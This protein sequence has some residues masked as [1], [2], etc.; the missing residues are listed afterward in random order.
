M[1]GNQP[2][3]VRG[4]PVAMSSWTRGLLACG[5]SVLGIAAIG[6][7]VGYCSLDNPQLVQGAA[8][9]AT[10]V[11]GGFGTDS[12]KR[13]YRSFRAR[14]GRPT[15]ENP[16]IL[17][18]LRS[19]QLSA[20]RTISTRFDKARRSDNDPSRRSHAELFM[21][22]LGQHL[23]REE[24][25]AETLV[26][27]DLPEPTDADIETL[28]FAVSRHA[29]ADP[30]I[31]RARTV[32]RASEDLSAA[33]SIR[34][35]GG[36]TLDRFRVAAEAAM[37]AELAAAVHPD[38]PPAFGHLLLGGRDS[39]DGWFALFIRAAAERLR[40][41]PGFRR[42]WQAEQDAVLLDLARQAVHGVAEVRHIGQAATKALARYGE[43]LGAVADTTKQA[44]DLL[45][46]MSE[47]L[48]DVRGWLHWN[49]NFKPEGWTRFH[50]FNRAIPFQGRE[51][52]LE[53][54]AAFLHTAGPFSWWIATGPGGAGKTRLALELCLRAHLGGWQVGFLRKPFDMPAATWR[55]ARPTLI[56][57]D[58]AGEQADRVRELAVLLSGLGEGLPVVRLLLLERVADDF[59]LRRFYGASGKDTGAIAATRYSDKWL[60]FGELSEDE[61]WSLVADCPWRV[62]P[63]ALVI[64]RAE[65]FAH[66][67]ET[68]RDHRVLVAMLIAEAMAEYPDRPTLTELTEVLQ[69]LLTN[70][71]ERHWPPELGTRGATA[72]R[73]GVAHPA[74]ALIAAATMTG[75]L[76]GDFLRDVERELG[77]AVSG[78]MLDCCAHAI[79]SPAHPDVRRLDG[80][81]PD[82]IGEFFALQAL[83]CDPR[84]PPRF[85]WLPELAWRAD[86]VRMA[87]FVRRARQNFPCHAAL[88]QI[89][90]VVRGVLE[91]WWLEAMRIWNDTAIAGSADKIT[92]VCE[93]LLPAADSDR[94]S[95]NAFARFC[96]FLSSSATGTIPLAQ[97]QTPLTELRGLLVRGREDPQFRQ[98]CAAT[99]INTLNH[100]KE[101]GALDRR[102][103]LLQ[104]LRAL[105]AADPSDA[106][107]RLGL[108]MGL[109]AT[110][111]DA[112]E[113]GALDRRDALLQE[114]RELHAAD[115]T[116]A[117]VR[118]QLASGLV[119]LYPAKEAVA[120]DRRDAL[121]QELR[122][123]H[124]A[125]PTDAA[126]REQL[127]SG[128]GLVIA[129]LVD[130]GQP[131]DLL[132]PGL[133]KEIIALA[134][135]YPKD[136]PLQELARHLPQG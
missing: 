61:L 66:L 88:G 63:V 110:L 103:A 46:A 101:E 78:F 129:P 71:R 20:L 48:D 97:M 26:E 92:A 24:K 130:K 72:S 106:A 121:L 109:V 57:A 107:V 126:V 105:H 120:L 2:G 100:A 122:A 118:L 51:A 68:D 65:F 11:L 15:D 18:G 89:E 56:I 4:L 28:R 35:G 119:M 41:D 25:L 77:T 73:I 123:L 54:L 36:P 91:S 75:H 59:F 79:G 38:I 127:A 52:E 93:Q 112:R 60:T 19:A 102:D 113:A 16:V 124:A 108:A 10:N 135:R 76:D 136:A 22:L 42:I 62:P 53:R 6:V 95:A 8:S 131:I 90:V 5:A 116:N 49:L 114:L 27:S 9:F 12:I 87:A 133:A 23:D 82:L 96:W 70:A 55:P 94:G 74:D 13:L 47:R 50:A 3:S 134:A 44:Y 30:T 58:Y 37:L 80:I 34:H 39:V 125:D 98:A 117:A 7:G 81:Q 1:S 17:R 132:E 85:P 14:P 67:R 84:D 21:R 86:E 32:R 69:E 31:A 29:G 99:L 64:S 111:H 33:L 115:P 83:V 45:R 104:E 128:L 43:T 40:D